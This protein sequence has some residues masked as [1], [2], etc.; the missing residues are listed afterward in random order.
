MLFSQG[1]LF[2]IKH[3]AAINEGPGNSRFVVLLGL[4]F[5]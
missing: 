1:Y 4:Y 2:S 3:S 5:I